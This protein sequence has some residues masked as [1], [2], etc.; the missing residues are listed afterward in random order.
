[1]FRYLYR[2]RRRILFG[3]FF[4]T[5]ALLLNYEETVEMENASLSLLLIFYTLSFVVFGV[6]IAALIALFIT[7]I[8][9]LRNII[10]LMSLFSFILA[11]I[12][13]FSPEFFSAD[14]G[15]WITSFTP[16]II[17]VTIGLLMQGSLLDKTRLQGRLKETRSF[18]SPKSANELWR[19]LIPG[20][21]PI[22]EYYDCLLSEVRIDQNDPNIIRTS[23]AQGQGLYRHEIFDILEEKPNKY[24][25]YSFSTEV[26][27]KARKRTTGTYEITIEPQE[28]GGCKVTLAT[29][30]VIPLFKNAILVWFDDA[31]GSRVDHIYAK[32]HGK[33]D[34]STVG[35]FRKNLEELI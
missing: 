13:Y 24:C 18:K 22:N 26:S 14:S 11:S 23:F 35:R 32:H 1:M 28:K 6:L 21:A 4:F 7:I 17:L 3:T 2:Q 8:P 10:E 33:R 9:E 5:M 27:S 34:W 15:H 25:K 20:K 19:E 16:I 30:E 29:D 31:L 12:T